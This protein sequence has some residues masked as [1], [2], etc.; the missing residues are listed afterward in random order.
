MSCARSTGGLREDA[1]ARPPRRRAPHARP[2][3]R[4]G[5]S[6]TGT[7]Q[8]LAGLGD[9]CHANG[10]PLIIDTVCTLGGI[11]FFGDAWG[12]DAMYSGS[13][14]VIGAPPGAHAGLTLP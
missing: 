2:A 8:N 1:E 5:D 14:K 10:T 4:Q 9:L 6:S 3:A 11:P 7:H 13:Q 12:V